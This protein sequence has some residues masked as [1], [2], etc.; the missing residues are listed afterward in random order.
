VTVIG[1]TQLDLE[2]V[3]T[4]HSTARSTSP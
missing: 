2:V 3:R 4:S 1:D